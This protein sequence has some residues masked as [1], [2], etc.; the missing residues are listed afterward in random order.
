MKFD[1]QGLGWEAFVRKRN[2]SYSLTLAKELVIGNGLKQ[3]D[4]L[5]YYLTKVD[6]RNA[7]VF[8]LD[9]QERSHENDH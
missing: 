4:K 8:F 1:F 2:Y 5:F 7:L 6:N 9:G 3:G